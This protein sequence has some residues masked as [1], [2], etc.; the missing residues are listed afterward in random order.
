VGSLITGGGSGGV[1][2]SA[3]AGCPRFR[4]T[5]PLLTGRT[6]R[7][8]AKSLGSP[9][10]GVGIPAARWVR[11]MAFERLVHDEAFVSELL[12]RAVGLLEME[13]PEAIRVRSA[14]D[15]VD[16]TAK[17]LEGAHLKAR[18]AGEA[19]MLFGLRVPFVG[20]EDTRATDVRP[21]FAIVARRVENGAIVGSWLVMGDAKDYERVRSRIDD[22]RMLKGFLQVA[23]GA[24]SAAAWGRLPGGMQ[25]HRHGVLAVPRNAYL[26]P[27]AV[28][29]DLADYR[30]EVHARV[31]ERVASRSESELEDT[32]D[33][34]LRKHV[35]HLEA[36]F[37]PASCPSCSL[38]RYCRGQLRGSIDPT[39]VLVEIGIRP[40]ERAAL[41]GL[42]DGTG[43]APPASTAQSLT[44]QVEATATGLPQRTGRL[45][46]DAV[47]LPGTIHVVAVKSDAASLGVHGIAMQR[48]EG[49]G[50]EAWERRIFERTNSTETRHAVMSLLGREIRRVFELGHGPVHLVVPD[51][52][53]ADLLVSIADSLAGIELSR[54]RWQRDIDEGREILTFDGEPA[55]LPD[56]LGEDARTAVSL[57]LEEDR[58]RAFGLRQPIIDLRGVLTTHVV[59]GGP[60]SD[61][62]RLDYVVAWAEATEPLDHRAV[63]DEI[64]EQWHTPGA[65]LSNVAS[66][67][68]HEAGRPE[69]GD[70]V[71]YERLVTEAL[72][73][74]IDVL[75]R[76][77]AALDTVPRSRLRDA[78]RTLEHDAQ[79]VWG[80]RLALQASDLVRFSRTYR[81]WRNA[82]VDMLDADRKC[83]DQLTALV[84]AQVAHDRAADAGVRELAFA[85][86]THTEPLR[87]D[88]QS[89]SITDGSRVALVHRPQ[90]PVVEDPHVLLKVQATSFKLSGMP[91]GRLTRDS[92]EAGALWSPVP[93]PAVVGLTTG[94]VV[95][96]ADADWFG[97]A[98][99][100]GHELA[101]T[102]PGLDGLAAPKVTC[103]PTSYATD[104]QAHQWCCR[105]HVAA[106][107]EWSDTIAERR[108]NGELNPQVWPPV[109]DQERFDLDES[110]DLTETT[111]PGPV[112]NGLT[113]DD[114][115]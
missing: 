67:E 112:P 29:E 25:V 45:R 10:T 43:T 103:K 88:V 37:D 12:T 105:P 35:R 14:N 31:Q 44:A 100:S 71:A 58:A 39:A 34:E 107:A 115:E 22:G 17:E 11:A 36:V 3:H 15:S 78:Y 32:T 41:V 111:D 51:K 24:E 92:E 1:A 48:V 28:V 5:D 65:R 2:S 75:L 85:V 19:T 110:T 47:G 77:V 18:H 61:A 98:F 70:P 106:E 23:L 8:L 13:R 6:R 86:V 91:I 55:S 4:A 30:R 108:A 69:R 9:D 26:R 89:R 83:R 66:D 84:D 33:D 73:Y 96:V 113:L 93:V 79:V 60:S 16:G 56:P 90:G 46:V 72:D 94:D 80:R 99:V 81:Y 50:H 21:D 7:S 42:V 74:R 54:L 76:A 109:V 82:Q 57:L 53:T 114:L 62:G 68:V 59:P 87:L 52:P 95:V 97:K 104:P 64:T 27:E 102:R 40:R 63:S 101:I 49:S 38:F 20:L